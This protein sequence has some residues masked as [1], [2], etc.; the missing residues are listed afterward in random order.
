M[1]FP[2]LCEPG[3]FPLSNAA[4]GGSS[5]IAGKRRKTSGQLGLGEGTVGTDGRLGNAPP[6]H[7]YMRG[8]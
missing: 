8:R 5:I 6:R 7:F 4:S 1:S 3:G 2:F